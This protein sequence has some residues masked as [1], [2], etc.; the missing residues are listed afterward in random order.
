M[1]IKIPFAFL[2]LSI[3]SLASL[4]QR[5][6]DGIATI[7]ANGV[8]NIYKEITANLTNGNF[9]IP[10]NNTTGLSEGDLVMIIQ[11][12]GAQVNYLAKDITFG[13]ISDYGNAGRFEFG[14][15]RKVNL[16]SIELTCG[17]KNNYTYKY[18]IGGSAPIYN[19]G[20]QIIRVPRY[21]KLTIPTGDT[22][23]A[24]QW[25]GTTG[26]I[27]VIE[28]LGN[29]QVEGSIDVS[30]KGFRGGIDEN[31]SNGDD[32]FV[33]TAYHPEIGGP[34]GTIGANKG[35]SIAGYVSTPT[36]PSTY[37][38]FGQYGTGAI[39]NGG[40]GG[41][42]HNGGGGGGANAVNPFSAWTG[43]GVRNSI[44]QPE[45][46][47]EM[48]NTNSPGGGRGGYT[49]GRGYHDPSIYGPGNII[50]AGNKRRNNGGLGGRPLKYAI[51]DSAKVFF[52]GGGGAGDANNNCGTNGGNG[53]GIIYIIAYGSVTGNGSL[54][55][56]GAN[57]PIASG[58][59][60]PNFQNDAA[61]GG[62]G[63]GSIIVQTLGSFGLT[64]ITANGGNGGNQNIPGND[65]AEGPGG[66]GGGGYILLPLLASGSKVYGGKNGTT[67]SNGV[68]DFTNSDPT[69]SFPSNGATSGADGL[70]GDTTLFSYFAKDTAA[71]PSNTVSSTAKGTLP[72]GAQFYWYRNY[73]DKDPLTPDDSVTVNG[74]TLSVI[75]PASGHKTFYLGICPGGTYRD[76]IV[77]TAKPCNSSIT[78]SS[79]TICAGATASLIAS[80]DA[81]PNDS[82]MVEW[83]L[84]DSSGTGTLITRKG[85]T[86][87]TVASFKDTL[88]TIPPTPSI[89]LKNLIY[90][91]K[92]VHFVS[93][94]RLDSAESTGT[95]RILNPSLANMDAVCKNA[96]AFALSGG[97]PASNAGGKGLYSGSGVTTD[98]LSF[99]PSKAVSL[100]NA[101]IYTYR[102]G[103]HSCPVSNSIVVNPN[104]DIAT[105]HTDIACNGLNGS[106]TISG[107]DPSTLY[108]VSYGGASPF[109]GNRASNAEGEIKL[110]IS[111]A[112]VYI[113]IKVISMEGCESNAKTEI[114]KKA[115]PVV[116]D[117]GP[118]QQL[119]ITDRNLTSIIAQLQGS[120]S[121]NHK[122]SWLLVPDSLKVGT[123]FG[124][125]P[126]LTL[127]R[128]KYTV[129]LTDSI[130]T[131][132]GRDSMKIIVRG[133]WIPDAISPNQ[134][135]THANELWL[136]HG[137]TDYDNYIVE[138]YNRY[139]NV[140]HRQENNFK[141]WDGTRNGV[142]LPVGTYYY[143]VE[144]P[145]VGNFTGPL[146]I[147]R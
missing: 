134:D 95:V 127:P 115:P 22:L 15:V 91:A 86:L 67:N 53:G 62:G 37:E 51:P 12:Q 58:C 43:T 81:V 90:T 6:K 59:P 74:N 9:T 52:G 80:I 26:G 7:P 73:T 129:H 123:L 63:G 113:N 18:S 36:I 28:S 13:S 23:T 111:K 87:R 68:N 99:D 46:D 102:E 14:E 100:T 122:P 54:N 34:D 103:S 145:G 118:D 133:L 56:N 108:K 121:V 143:V 45:W 42:H 49:Y 40:G 144:V 57:A 2:L 147:I 50:W 141:G 138:V 69:K 21:I 60:T 76:T 27:V 64:S 107:L 65:E 10:V 117:A 16:N 89:N 114:V 4:A 17:L 96:P 72:A 104:P 105:S 33:T 48:L 137:I 79:D 83:Y 38:I 84:G 77:V 98:G 85:P 119:N 3:I 142:P 25:N 47:L 1:R 146:T 78:V 88:I 136:L 125:S 132:V 31:L 5:G 61:S 75:L 124:L 29:V 41:G 109:S 39:A 55:A 11:M 112:L 44:F 110:A 131:C 93:G 71:C 97:S 126:S 19:A 30:G 70:K 32:A 128:G 8:V 66:G 120:S 130:S 101:I 135:P 24:Q 94:V 116:V 92:Y 106:I 140:V 35:E 20:T 82:Y 139:G